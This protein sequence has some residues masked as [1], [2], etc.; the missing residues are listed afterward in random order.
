MSEGFPSSNDDQSKIYKQWQ[1][2]PA[3]APLDRKLGWLDESCEE[4]NAWL[5]VQRGSSDWRKALDVIAGKL[6]ATIPAYRSQMNT[7]L[8]KRNVREVVGT[9]AKLRP[10]W[11][12]GSDNQAF[13]AQA[14]TMN[15]VTK[16]LYLENFYDLKIKE[17]L[18]YAAATCTGWIRPIYARDMAGTGSGRV[19]LLSY[20]GPCVLPVQLPSS[21]DFQ[22]AYAV[23]ILDEMPIYMAH[24]M[25]HKYQEELHPTSSLYWYSPEIRDSAKGNLW[26]RLFSW[27][28]SAATKNSNLSDLMIPVRYTYIIDLTV[29]KTDQM[30]PM[31]E[32]DT[33]WYYE[34]PAL[35]HD[36]PMGTDAHG[37]KLSRKAS[38]N[39]AR[40]YP[41]RRLIISSESC[42]M[43]DGPS[44]DWHGHVPAIPFSTDR[45]PWEPLG[46]S[47]VRDGYDIQL[48]IN[49][50]WRGVVDKC[51]AQNDMALGYDINT[52]SLKQAKEFDPMQP[53]ARMGFDSSMVDEPFK[54]IV[55]PEVMKVAP[56]L[57]ESINLLKETM[58][59][60]MAITDMM[61]LAKARLAG[62]DIEKLLEA[63][64]PIVEDMS[65]SME[66]SMQ[67]IG[68]QL[69]YLILQYMDTAR[70]MQYVGADGMSKEIFDY[71]PSS[72]V[73]SH[74]PGDNP[75]LGDSPIPSPTDRNRRGRV[76]AGNLRYFITPNS[77]HELTQLQYKL[78][79][80]QL[81]KA[82][83]GID[84]ESIAEA[85]G[86]PNY[87]TIDGNTVRDKF[88]N[89]Q[90]ESLIFAMKM[91]QLQASLQ[92]A[93]Q[94]GP[95]VGAMVDQ[96][97]N[98]TQEGR[99]PSGQQGP[100][101]KTKEGGTRTTITESNGGGRKV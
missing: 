66:P 40:L 12:Y 95:D 20:G 13:K 37:N 98:P 16:A 30:I 74:L 19:R 59:D 79:L 11:G 69:K 80:I 6:D 7:N 34:V 49:E 81:K 48:A 4:G 73:P 65:R 83:V 33:S 41:Y 10:I 26:Q 92:Q 29:N 56:E 70:V 28:R 54:P 52:M 18:Q 22:Q 67:E 42:V 23:T 88:K 90:E 99:P 25:F 94:G 50:L 35:N 44:F 82:G 57:F 31:G 75:G 93:A 96:L 2:P 86:I 1:V 63:N 43:Y 24:G 78:G 61:A 58:N 39:D 71:D 53:R 27:G 60:Q 55:P 45:W 38:V 9:L 64:G 17:A 36:I 77:L 84:S 97:M 72:L 3:A 15:K 87:G 32:Q 76:V 8:L 101:M 89:E 68:D 85:W 14:E 91:G 5:K 51:R 46:F 47:M 62:D 100:A 21:G